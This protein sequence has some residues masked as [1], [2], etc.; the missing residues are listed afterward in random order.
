[1]TGE[2]CGVCGMALLGGRCVFPMC[3]SHGNAPP[4]TGVLTVDCTEHRTM[5]RADRIESIAY[6]KSEAV[7]TLR[8]LSG[9]QLEVPG[10]H[11]D[12]IARELRWVTIAASKSGV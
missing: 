12:H 10:D 9:D 7:T 4:P 11:V 1:M 3:A 6:D 5:V 8:T 2:L